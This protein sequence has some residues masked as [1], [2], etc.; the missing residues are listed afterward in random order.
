MAFNLPNDT[1]CGKHMQSNAFTH[2][3]TDLFRA[4]EDAA[5]LGT[6]LGKVESKAQ[7]ATVIKLYERLRKERTLKIREETFRQQEEFHLVDGEAQELRDRELAV[8]LETHERSNF[9]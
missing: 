6:L 8:S 1:F 4:L 3:R 7:I 5:M 2:F 9:W